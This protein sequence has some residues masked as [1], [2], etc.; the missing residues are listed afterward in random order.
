MLELLGAGLSNRDI[1]ARL[2]LSAA[3]VKTHV[4]RVLG[5]P[6]LNSRAQAVVFA[7][8]P[9]VVTAGRSDRC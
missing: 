7:H 9:G 6:G 4:G 8:E 3:T 1:A 2:V 5:K